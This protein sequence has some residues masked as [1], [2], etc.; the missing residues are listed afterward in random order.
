MAALTLSSHTG[1]SVHVDHCGPC[2]QIWFDAL[3][4]VAL[5]ARGW[6]R[7]L[8]AL[9]DGGQ[10]PAADAAPPRGGLS[11]PSCRAPLK[12]V[13]NQS[14]FGRFTAL[15]CPQRHGHLHGQAGVL[16]ERG[17]VRLLQA[18]ERKALQ[19]ER[20]RITCFNCGAPADGQA[21]HCGYCQSPL[22]VLDVPRL[23][24]SLQPRLVDQ[25][26]TRAEPGRPMPWRCRGCG[27]ALD[28]ARDAQCPQCGHLVVSLDLP[29]LGPLLDAAEAAL[30]DKAQQQ[31]ARRAPAPVGRVRLAEGAYGPPRLDRRADDILEDLRR[32]TRQW[33][34]SWELGRLLLHWLQLL[35]RR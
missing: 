3:E 20:H 24:R 19:E 35:L 16:A 12:T 25:G 14:R 29:D 28:P 6:I 32:D 34:W 22:V 33:T 5:D 17:L 1:R 18:P 23:A 8:R 26:Q 15:E 21:D 9:Q 30:D 11:C 7:L 2:R 10:A 27:H 13:A 4:S 31:A